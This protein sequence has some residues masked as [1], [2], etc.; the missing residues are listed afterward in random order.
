MTQNKL[1]SRTLGR[2]VWILNLLMGW[3]VNEWKHETNSS[4]LPT[5][6]VEGA[7]NRMLAYV[8]GAE[9]QGGV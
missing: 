9:L 6:S 8:G 3:E 7:H 2:Y 4:Y 1:S 5:V